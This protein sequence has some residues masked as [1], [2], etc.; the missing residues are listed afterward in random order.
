[1]TGAGGNSGGG[2]GTGAGG[3]MG[4]HVVDQGFKCVC[5]IDP[6]RPLASD[7]GELAAIGIVALALLGIRRRRASSRPRA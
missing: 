2:G 4:P 3:T 1:M 5:A 7:L 6:A